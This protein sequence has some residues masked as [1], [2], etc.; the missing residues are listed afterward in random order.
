MTPTTW[1]V[2]M[3]YPTQWVQANTTSRYVVTLTDE[4]AAA[5]T[6]AQIS[7]VTLNVFD[8]EV[9]PPTLVA[10]SWPRDI[11][12]INGGAVAQNGVL[13]LTMAREDNFLIDP[14]KSYET[15]RWVIEWT[16]ASGSKTQ[17]LNVDRIVNK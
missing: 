16:Y 8:L 12:N 3:F 5:L 13:T 7:S 2:R 4:S 15:R 10:G 9:S 11:K 17:R 14:L 6:L 1:H